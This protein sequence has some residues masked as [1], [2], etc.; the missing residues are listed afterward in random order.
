M[1]GCRCLCRLMCWAW[2][3]C[4]GWWAVLSEKGLICCDKGLHYAGTVALCQGFPELPGIQKPGE[5][6]KWKESKLLVLKA[7]VLPSH[8]PD[9][10]AGWSWLLGMGHTLSCLSKCSF[11]A[12]AYGRESVY[13]HLL[14]LLAMALRKISPRIQ[15]RP[16]PFWGKMMWELQLQ[17][18]LV[19]V[20]LLLSWRSWYCV[21]ILMWTRV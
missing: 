20:Y 8:C 19:D 13:Q 5:W 18:K 14:S 6:P 17:F 12:G 3:K 10:G 21:W 11:S 9:R 16:F 15:E 4:S 2:G 1:S 7:S